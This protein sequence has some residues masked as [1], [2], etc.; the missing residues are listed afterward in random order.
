MAANAGNG[1]VLSEQGRVAMSDPDIVL[2]QLD[3]LDIGIENDPVVRAA[4][5]DDAIIDGAPT[6][7][8]ATKT[9]QAGSNVP[10]GGAAEEEVAKEEEAEESARVAEDGADAEEGEAEGEA[11]E[12]AG[13]EEEL[14]ATELKL[15]QVETEKAALEILVGGGD[16][17]VEAPP[18]P[19]QPAATAPVE[20]PVQPPPGPLPM[21]TVQAPD[22]T[23]E[24]HAEMLSDPKAMEDYIQQRVSLGM[25]NAMLAMPG[26]ANDV[27][28]TQRS[29]D[30]FFAQEE[31]KDVA[32]PAVKEL[33][34]KVAAGMQNAGP[35]VTV[36]GALSAAA[37]KV[38]E[39][40]EKKTGVPMRAAKSAKKAKPDQ[41]KKT[42]AQPTSGRAAAETTAQN[43][44][45]TTLERQLKEL[46]EGL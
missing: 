33:V 9:P 43:D 7:E 45:Q 39:Q 37:D 15:Q 42:F 44:E 27:I 29:V 3:A 21:P 4:Q 11:A 26:V 14:S 22:L 24:K 25:Q 17:G 28:N 13:K 12:E 34:T 5:V 32:N 46:D 40:V 16:L 19:A 38:R 1:P 20:T 8:E 2:P 10:E 31:N 36:A 18:A 35:N 6:N 41:K 23:P 30:D